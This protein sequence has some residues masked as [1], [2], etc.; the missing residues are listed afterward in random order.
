MGTRPLIGT[1]LLSIMLVF[2]L[3]LL[4]IDTDLIALA[5]PVM[6]AGGGGIIY[7]ALWRPGGQSMR[8]R[9]HL[10][11]ALVAATMLVVA[12]AE[13]PYGYY[14]IL[15][16]VV[17]G[18]A[19]YI[20]YMSYRWGKV[21]ATWV[22]GFLAALFNPI[23]PVHLTKEIWQPIDTIS[24]MWFWSSTLFLKEPGRVQEDS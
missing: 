16:W 19:I 10:M 6:I 20:A 21:W 15:R 4:M 5:I 11:P 24:A 14:Q 23:V 7:L 17:C 1:I 2:S 12:V 8:D 9:P 13:L 18:V 22:F 3:L